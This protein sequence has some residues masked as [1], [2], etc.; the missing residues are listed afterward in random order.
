[1]AKRRSERRYT[2]HERWNG[3][4][5]Y[6]CIFEFPSGRVCGHDTRDPKAAEAHDRSHDPPPPHKP[7]NVVRTDRFGNPLPEE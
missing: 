1:M 3:Q 7:P 4:K 2:D 5:V 6:R